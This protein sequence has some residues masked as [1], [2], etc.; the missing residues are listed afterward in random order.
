MPS[1]IYI[2]TEEHRKKLSE[3][4]KGNKNALGYMHSE[5]AK[6]KISEANKGRKASEETKL[7]M[8]KAHKGKQTVLGKHWKLSAETKKRI[9]ENNA[10]YWTGKHFSKDTKRKIRE[11]M[12]AYIMKN[13]G[14]VSPIRGKNEI[15]ILDTIQQRMLFQMIRQFKVAG[16]FIDAYLP[17]LKLAIEIDERPK[18]KQKDI[19]REETIKKELGC[20]FLRIKDYI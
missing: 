17:E 4:L 16:Y 11:S 12:L 1:R 19:D 6:K 7:K 3:V 10:R 8:G 20:Q 18:N 9:S 14:L 13:N 2:K 5:E 15:K